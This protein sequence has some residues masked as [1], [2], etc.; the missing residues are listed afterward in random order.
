VSGRTYSLIFALLAGGFIGGSQLN[1]IL[2]RKSQ[3]ETLFFR[4][5]VVQVVAGLI[6]MTGSWMGGYGLASTILLIFLFL[7]CVGIT[8]PNASALAIGP[9]TKN[10]GSASALLGFFQLGTG[11]VISTGITAATPHDS[12]PI[13]SI[14]ALTAVVGLV[15]LLMRRNRAHSSAMTEHPIPIADSNGIREDIKGETCRL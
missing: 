15:I 11:A 10:A 5:L 4:F 9:F 6:F 12:R 1:V 2:L 8:N 13:I 3:S 7:S 14:L